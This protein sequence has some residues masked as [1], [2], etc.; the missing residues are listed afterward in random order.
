MKP[1]YEIRELVST[2][3]RLESENL[4][5]GSPALDAWYYIRYRVFKAVTKELGLYYEKENT[6][7]RNYFSLVSEYM[8]NISRFF[9]S[10]T[11]NPLLPKYSKKEYVFFGHP[12]RKF[13]EDGRYWDAYTDFIVMNF[14]NGNSV[15]FEKPYSNVHLKPTP[16]NTVAHLDGLNFLERLIAMRMKIDIPE[17]VVSGLESMSGALYQEMNVNI[18]V[19]KIGLRRYRKFRIKQEAVKILLKRIKPKIVFLVCSYGLEYLVQACRDLKIPTVELQHGVISHYHVGYECAGTHPKKSF[20]DYLFTFGKYW[21]QA[22]HFPIP[23]DRIFPVGYPFLEE[24]I[25]SMKSCE[26]TMQVLFISQGTIG[27]KLGE[28]AVRFAEMNRDVKVVFKLHPVEFTRWRGQYHM[29]RE[30]EEKGLLRVI[31]TKTPSLYSL[32]CESAVQVGVYSTAL[33]EGIRFGCRT[34]LLNLPGIEYMDDFIAYGFGTVVNEPGDI[35][36]PEDSAPLPFET[37]S[38]F[39]RDWRGNFSAAV[40]SILRQWKT[41]NP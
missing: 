8:E 15:T 7:K 29:L 14:F 17:E 38:L 22:A 12:R 30:A 33:F 10:I 19:L 25:A 2:I 18:D 1:V 27:K 32:F 24:K 37:D 36:V 5:P 11:H 9:S 35:A 4:Q 26:K 41:E 13:E 3:K 16:T 39:E 6:S 28:F 40:D 34:Y 21:K 23:Q 20:P 31:D